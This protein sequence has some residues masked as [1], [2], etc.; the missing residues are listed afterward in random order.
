MLSPF[1]LLPRDGGE[2][3]LVIRVGSWTCEWV[4]K[5]DSA[6][7]TVRKKKKWTPP[8]Y[9]MCLSV[10]SSWAV[11]I[12]HELKIISAL[13]ENEAVIT[14]KCA[15]GM[16]EESSVSQFT[17][18]PGGCRG[19]LGP[20]IMW[21]PLEE[22]GTERNQHLRGNGG[23]SGWPLIQQDTHWPAAYGGWM[24]KSLGWT[25]FSLLLVTQT[26]TKCQALGVG[27]T[28]NKSGIHDPPFQRKCYG[29]ML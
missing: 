13:L 10:S 22:Y 18:G 16:W 4:S 19:D 15:Q 9:K 25:A 28:N 14:V 27:M 5:R 8:C 2:W 29:L 1:L 23:W 7:P 21:S 12:I 6:G 3:P 26:T 20:F 17:E 11:S 24:F